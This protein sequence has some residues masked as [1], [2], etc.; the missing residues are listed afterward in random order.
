[1]TAQRPHD[2]W[3]AGLDQDHVK[4]SESAPVPADID[5]DRFAWSLEVLHA[6]LGTEWLQRELDSRLP[7]HGYLLF[8]G[9]EDSEEHP[10]D[11]QLRLYRAHALASDLVG[12]QQLRGFSGW[13]AELPRR[14]LREAAAELRTARHMFGAGGEVELLTA[15]TAGRSPDLRFR[16]DGRDVW[17]EVKA[18]EDR[19]APSFREGSITSSLKKAAKQLPRDAPGLI[20]LHLPHTWGDDA[21]VLPKADDAARSWLRQ[22][23]RVNAIVI[24][25]ERRLPIPGGGLRFST[26]HYT[27]PNPNPR[28]SLP[29]IQGWL[30]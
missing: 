17:V 8:G 23:G 21:E 30:T 22:T 3:L 5:R 20:Y 4:A 18:K 12:A 24:M 11:Q 26:A 1:V 16:L 28:V 15:S 7:G 10:D 2:L 6:F 13:L 25:L 29:G 9:D 14:S 19:P 27:L